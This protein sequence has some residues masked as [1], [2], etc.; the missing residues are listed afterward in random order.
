MTKGKQL[1]TK[2]KAANLVKAKA[3][4]LQDRLEKE[5]NGNKKTF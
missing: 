5:A 2:Q 1:T 4:A 3:Q